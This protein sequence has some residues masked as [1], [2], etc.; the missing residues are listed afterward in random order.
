GKTFDRA[1]SATI[2]PGYWLVDLRAQ[3]RMAEGL[4]LNARV[5][6]VGNKQYETT[7]GYGSLGRTVYLGLR[8]RF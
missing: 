8:S 4:T 2:L 1:G 7:G 3:W 6:N 5:E